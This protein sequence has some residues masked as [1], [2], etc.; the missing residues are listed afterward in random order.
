MES[1]ANGL[2]FFAR[3]RLP[4]LVT[5]PS[6]SPRRGDRLAVRRA[7]CLEFLD[8]RNP[9]DG[10]S[11]RWR[12]RHRRRLD[13]TPRDLST[14]VAPMLPRRQVNLLNMIW[15]MHQRAA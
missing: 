4:W 8:Y 3:E 12:G 6:L 15:S 11:G 1:P 2:F 5:S 13:D 14:Q 9:G 10:R 7:R